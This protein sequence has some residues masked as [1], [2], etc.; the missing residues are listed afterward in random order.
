MADKR[1]RMQD[2]ILSHEVSHLILRA[3]SRKTR[4]TLGYLEQVGLLGND[5]FAIVD[6][7]WHGRL[8]AS[9]SRLLTI[10]K[11]RPVPA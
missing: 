8:Q 6:I 11:V 2:C 9:L 1:K 7:G 4:A 10:A 3:A 5:A